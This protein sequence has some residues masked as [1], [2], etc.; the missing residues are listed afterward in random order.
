MG[1]IEGDIRVPPARDRPGAVKR[2]HVGG[3]ELSLADPA[4]EPV[5][6]RRCDL[7]PCRRG[8]RRGVLPSGAVPGRALCAECVALAL[9]G[10]EAAHRQAT[11][12][13]VGVDGRGAVVAGVWL[14]V[15]YLLLSSFSNSTM[16]A[17]SSG[18]F[19]Y[20]D[21]IPRRCQHGLKRPCRGAAADL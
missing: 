12:L 2:G 17:S 8:Y 14:H 5:R 1:H 6:G 4:V 15:G 18:I 21:E 20:F 13:R 9:R 11:P 7:S 3:V 19:I 10:I 16:R